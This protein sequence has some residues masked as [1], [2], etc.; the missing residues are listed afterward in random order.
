MKVVI[1]GSK[2]YLGQEFLTVFPNAVCP[3]VDIA[4]RA[5]VAEVLDREK[6]DVMINTAGKTG[7]PNV[8]WCETHKEETLHANVLG[9]LVLQE[10]CRKRGIYWMQISSGCIYEGNKGGKGFTED[11]EPNFYGSFYSRSKIWSDQMLRE[12]F[13]SP[14]EKGGVLILRLRMPFG[15]S[16]N[17]RSLIT[18]ISKYPKVLDVQNSLTY[19]PDFLKAADLLIQ[20]RKT[21]IYNVVNPGIISPYEIMTMYKEI[22]DPSREFQ[23][24]TLD[25]LSDVVRAGRSNCMLN[26][27]KLLKEGI[28]MTPI[29]EAVEKALRSIAATK[30]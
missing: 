28:V 12:L 30:N 29:K 2:G 8:D 5:A 25:H 16:L 1:F 13:D 24:L 7:R 4:D 27:E 26:C 17:D 22:V 15:D 10:E 6:P 20:K 9:P 18:K 21:G 23:K 19:L 14:G 11:D 3:S